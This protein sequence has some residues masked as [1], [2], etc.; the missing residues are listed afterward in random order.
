MLTMLTPKEMWQCDACE[1]IK[2]HIIVE[3]LDGTV[4][5]DLGRAT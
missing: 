3:N 1:S 2:H 4:P 5:L